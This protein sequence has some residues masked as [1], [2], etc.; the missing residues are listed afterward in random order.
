MAVTSQGYGTPKILAWIFKLHGK[1]HFF[2]VFFYCIPLPTSVHLTATPYG[3]TICP[4]SMSFVL[5]VVL[6]GKHIPL[7]Q[8]CCPKSGKEAVMKCVST[9]SIPSK[10]SND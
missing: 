6:M 5:F 4:I 7:L 3:L 8:G 10:I 1:P 2:V 9:W